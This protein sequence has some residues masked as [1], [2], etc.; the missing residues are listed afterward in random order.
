MRTEEK[1]H[2]RKWMRRLELFCGVEVMTYCLMET[3]FHLLVRVPCRDE[4]LEREPLTAARLRKLLPLIYRGRELKHALQELDR[5]AA[6][7]SG[8]WLAKVLNRYE[9]RK[10]AGQ[11]M[12]GADWGG[13]QVLRGLNTNSRVILVE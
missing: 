3:H 13:L 12:K 1:R 10:Q 8:K 4:R 11:E 9:A 5:A 7:D 6:Q 2:F